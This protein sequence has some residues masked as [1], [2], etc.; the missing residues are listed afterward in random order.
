MLKYRVIVVAAALGIVAGCSEP[1]AVPSP[2]GSGE[3]TIITPGE[4]PAPP[5]K[6]PKPYKHKHRHRRHYVPKAVVVVPEAPAMSVEV[7]GCYVPPMVSSPSPLD[8]MIQ[9]P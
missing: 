9:A 8:G 4:A 2:I 1:A 6:P 7:Q 3:I 5:V